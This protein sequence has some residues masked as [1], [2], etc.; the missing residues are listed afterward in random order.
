[1]EVGGEAWMAPGRG[2]AERRRRGEVG[3]AEGRM[4]VEAAARRAG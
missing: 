3:R 4:K 2:E 1:M